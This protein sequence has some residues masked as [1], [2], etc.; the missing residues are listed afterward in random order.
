[1]HYGEIVSGV[2]ISRPNRF[3]AQVAIDG[4]TETVHVKNT[5]RCKELLTEGARVILE[6]FPE[7]S[8]RKTMYDLIA[9]YK[10][11]LLI[12][13]DSQSPNKAVKE[14]IPQLFENT[15]LIRPETSYGKSRFDFYIQAGSR[16]IFMEVKGCTLEENGICRFP[17]APTERGVK[18]INELVSCIEDGYE[19]YILFVIQMERAKYFTP[20]TDTHPEFAEAL[21]AASSKGVNILAYTCTV[22]ESSMEIA[23]PL[24]IKL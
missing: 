11:D 8:S 12:N 17:D 19:A 14:F 2:F 20:N 5:G 3:I 15:T 21:K 4:K 13:M 6:K 9:V 10:G 7:S 24:T 22:T 18:H 16:R 1:M 23:K